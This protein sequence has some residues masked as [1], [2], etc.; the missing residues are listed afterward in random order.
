MVTIEPRKRVIGHPH[1]A[2]AVG[3]Q[4]GERALDGGDL[5]DDVVHVAPR[6]E[7]APRSG[8]DQDANII[9]LR[10]L[11]ESGLLI[12]RSRGCVVLTRKALDYLHEPQSMTLMY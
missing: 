10:K 7:A 1:P 4:H 3:G 8:D 12:R 11:G 9:A 2:R 6:V 5:A